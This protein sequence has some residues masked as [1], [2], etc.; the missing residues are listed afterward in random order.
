MPPSASDSAVTAVRDHFGISQQHMAVW[1]GVTQANASQL[2]SGRRGL[3]P[4]AAEALAP[5]IRQLP[6]PDAPLPA[7]APP[8]P[9]ALAPPEAGPLAARLDY[10]QHHARRL[11]RQ[12]RPLEAQAAVAARWAEAL[13]AIRAALP[14]D[15]GPAAKPD[16]LMDRAAWHNWYRHR[17]LD[18]RPTALP[19]DLSAQY[20]LWRLQ[21]E[22][23]E[24]E[25]AALRALLPGGAALPF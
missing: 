3:S 24:T 4:A 13:P 23:L 5:L 14:P 1:L 25:A 16:P 7:A 10:C 20:H 12:L 19:P 6:P 17:W 9:L 15:P 2:E 8:P 22:A 11:R 18:L 21:A